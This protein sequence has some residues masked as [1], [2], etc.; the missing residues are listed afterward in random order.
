M[1]DH[2]KVGKPLSAAELDAL[3]EVN[4][5]VDVPAAERLWDEAVAKNPATKWAV[6]LLSAVP[7]EDV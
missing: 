2:R 3:A 4:P 6:G 7:A 5:A 1:I